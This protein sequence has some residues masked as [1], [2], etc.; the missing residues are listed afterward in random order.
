MPNVA[1]KLNLSKAQIDAVRQSNLWQKRE[2]TEDEQNYLRS[3]LVRGNPN[4]QVYVDMVVADF[5]DILGEEEKE[6]LE[7]AINS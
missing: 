3:L 1:G 5:V 4:N 7:K 2:L 6:A